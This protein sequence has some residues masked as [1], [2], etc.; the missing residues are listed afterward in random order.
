MA[1]LALIVSL[2]VCAVGV[3][4]GL[5]GL[6]LWWRF[7]ADQRYW[8]AVRA[9]QV[10][11]LALVLLA[12]VV[13][14]GGDKPD[15]WLFW[16]YTLVPIAVSFVAEQM[17]LIAADQVLERRGLEG[18]ADVET[19]DAAGQRGVVR[20]IVRREIGIMTTSAFVIAFLALRVVA[21]RGGL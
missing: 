5:W 21:E 19:L 13:Y 18:A 4:S 14:I 15:G 17:R 1:S 2:A 9:T 11:A 10:G 8:V 7:D 3:A 16:I 6:W 12:G 20:E